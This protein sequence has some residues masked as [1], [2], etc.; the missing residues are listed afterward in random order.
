MQRLVE[1]IYVNKLRMKEIPLE[2]KLIESNGMKETAKRKFRCAISKYDVENLNGRIYSKKLW[3]KVIKE[4]KD[5]WDGCVCL[6]D[7]PS[8]DDDGSVKN[9]VG[10]WNNL[11]FGEKT[12]EKLVYADITFIG[13][14]GQ[15]AID[16]MEAGGKIGFSSS[17]FGDLKENSKYI[18]ESTY[19]IERIADWVLNPSQQVFGFLQDELEES[20]NNDKVDILKEE[21]TNILVEKDNKEN[22]YMLTDIEKK[23]FKMGI[24]NLKEKAFNEADLNKRL[25]RFKEIVDY[26]HGIEE[27]KEALEEAKVEISKIEEEILALADKGKKLDETV[28]KMEEISKEKEEIVSKVT[29]SQTKISKLSEKYEIAKSMLEDFKIREKSIKNLYERAIAEKN[30]MIEAEKYVELNKYTKTLE[31]QLKELTKKINKL[32]KENVSLKESKDEE[33]SKMRREMKVFMKLHKKYEAKD[34]DDEDDDDEDEVEEKACKKE[35]YNFRNTDKVKEFYMDVKSQFPQV[36]KIK[37]EILKAKT[38]QEASRTWMLLKDLVLEENVKS[39]KDIQ[40]HEKTDDII[41]ISKEETSLFI[42]NGW[43]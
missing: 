34:D 22:S 40:K 12:Q 43:V 37:E 31:D 10:I 1:G 35:S 11:H 25:S 38:V 15:K 6:A 9:I 39:L 18:D 33:I 28:S 26:T 14:L 8:G 19:Q 2:E 13:D 16:I 23:N 21:V 3:E 42:R 17:G 7:H 29:E 30:G 32:E 27:G 41:P 24:S 36:V 4:Q 20:K 5:V